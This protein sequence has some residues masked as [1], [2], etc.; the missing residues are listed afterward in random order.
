MKDATQEVIKTLNASN[1][2]RGGG[3][4]EL[5]RYCI[6]KEWSEAKNYAESEAWDRFFGEVYNGVF[7]RSVQPKL[8]RIGGV[9]G[10]IQEEIHSALS[11]AIRAV[12][13]AH[14]SE[15]PLF[16]FEGLLTQCCAEVEFSNILEPVFFFPLLFPVLVAGHFPCGWDGDPVPENWLPNGPQD[17]PKGRLMVHLINV[18]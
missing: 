9:M 16:P 14:W 3:V 7:I 12:R 1:I 17:L 18:K 5:S 6:V 11:P 4:L 13:E 2:T 8:K 15:I 10:D